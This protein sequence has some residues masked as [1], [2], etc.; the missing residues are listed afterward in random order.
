VNL[1]RAFPRFV[2]V[3]LGLLAIAAGILTIGQRDTEAD[4]TATS[5]SPSGTSAL[6]AVFKKA[7]YTVRVD[8]RSHPKLASNEVAVAF[9]VDGIPAYQATGRSEAL[10]T[11]TDEIRN[12]GGRAVLARIPYDFLRNSQG[13]LAGKPLSVETNPGEKNLSIYG[14]DTGQV[15]DSAIPNMGS[16]D[17]NIGLW[18]AQAGTESEDETTGTPIVRA[19]Q[20]GK[21]QILEVANASFMTNRFLDK[22]QDADAAVRLVS[23]LAP[24]GSTIVFTEATIGNIEDPGLLESIGG[25]A[26]AAWRQLLVLGLVVVYTLGKRFGLPDETRPIQRG[27]RELLDGLTDTYFRGRHVKAA[28][29]AAL[30]R[31]NQELRSALRLPRDATRAERDELLPTSLKTALSNLQR[32]YESDDKIG[33]DEVLKLVAAARTESNEFL[34]GTRLRQETLA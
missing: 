33:S 3:L 30:D 11:F 21:G 28:M 6:A 10:Q 25:W 13:L 24:A 26:L 27:A 15:F 29:G 8:T 9:H 14:V 4:P 32:A 1:L 23:M 5:F 20:L 19:V 17:A 34:R 2:W 22:A 18:E 7:G 12:S 16:D 31:T